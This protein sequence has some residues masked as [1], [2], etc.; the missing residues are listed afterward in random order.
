MC[1]GLRTDF[2][3][4]GFKASTRLLEIAHSIEEMKTICPC[5]KKAIFNSRKINGKFTFEGSQVA[6]DDNAKI[7]YISLCPKCYFEKLRKY[8]KLKQSCVKEN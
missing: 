4:R 7:E 2:R 8:Q 6:I 5:G 1:Y 3:T